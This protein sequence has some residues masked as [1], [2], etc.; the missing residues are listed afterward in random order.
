MKLNYINIVSNFILSSVY[1][2]KVK[3]DIVQDDFLKDTVRAEL[4]TKT[5]YNVP[6]IYINMEQ[7]SLEELFNQGKS[8]GSMGGMGGMAPPK[9]DK[10]K[11]NGGNGM[12]PPMNDKDK[13]KGGNDMPQGMPSNQKPPS[14]NE[15]EERFKVTNATLEFVLNG[16][17]K[18]IDSISISIGGQNSSFYKK[19]GYNIKCNKGNLYGRK[20]LRLR[21]VV[22]DASFLRNK[23]SCDVLNRLGGPSISANYAR[24]FFNGTYSGLFVLMDAYKT[25]WIK[26]VYEEDKEVSTLYQC[27]SPNADFSE[28]NNKSCVNANDDFNGDMK[29]M[30][31]FIQ[32]INAASSRK[33]LEDIMD[34][35]QF[36]QVWIFEWLTGSWDSSLIIGKNYYLYKQLNGKWVMLPF[37]FDS[38]F[39]HKVQQNFEGDVN[40]YD[41]PFDKWYKSRYI[42]DVLAKNDN[43]TF[44]NN[45]QYVLD[46]AFNPDLLFP[47][48][49]SLKT[50][51][52]PY[53]EEDHTPVNG[54]YPGYVSKKSTSTRV[55]F[56][57]EEFDANCEYTDVQYGIGLK[58]WIQ[59]RYDFVC[60]YYPV[61][62]NSSKSPEETTSTTIEEV[63]PTATTTTEATST[64]DSTTTITPISEDDCWS[65]VLGYSCCSS[66][67][68]VTADESGLWGAENGQWCGIP[69]NCQ[70]Q[71]DQCWSSY[72]G[73]PCCSHCKLFLTDEL[74]Q[75]GAENGEWCGI[76]KNKC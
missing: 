29:A 67:Q 24:V 47:H 42:V 46:N 17:K 55:P 50:W 53:V 60:S 69:S 75:W 6:D 66:C 31:D 59:N 9:D 72:Y 33:E 30:E 58:K 64:I 41:I 40:A 13:P 35:D 12:S 32:A 52:T 56:S 68:V 27:N 49:N 28:N 39:G 54:T 11:P 51:L 10:G 76:D 73:Y 57:M 3:G 38:T 8:R 25:S 5:D 43:T 19:L 21:S 36:V 7:A 1:L 45:L 26:K 48:I 2:I 61:T 65:K 18:K 63:T 4:F 70:T 16:E 37:D 23:L 71:Y 20:V 34:V 74:G 44:I 62:C 14:S 22:E 15:K